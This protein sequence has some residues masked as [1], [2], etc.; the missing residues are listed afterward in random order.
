[1][2]KNKQIKRLILSEQRSN[3]WRFYDSPGWNF[4]AFSPTIKL[5]LHPLRWSIITSYCSLA[6]LKGS[7][8]FKFRRFRPRGSFSPFSQIQFC[9]LHAGQLP[10]SEITKFEQP[11]GGKCWPRVEVETF[12][13]IVE[14][15]NQSKSN[16][17]FLLVSIVTEYRQHFS[18]P[19]PLQWQYKH[20]Q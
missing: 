16:S 13:L 3:V 6:N 20:T 7:L 18:G 11:S 2:V 17:L 12:E 5:T 14:V 4:L 8:N 10:R 9:K 1:M 15:I 19:K